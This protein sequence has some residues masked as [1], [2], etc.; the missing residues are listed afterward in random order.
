MLVTASNFGSAISHLH[1]WKGRRLGVDTETTGLEWATKDKMVGVSVWCPEFGYYFPFRH[2]TGNLTFKNMAVLL[3]ELEQQHIVGFNTKFD[4]HI[5]RKD[6]MRYP[7]HIPENAHLLSQLADENEPSLELKALCAR[8]FGPESV[9]ESQKLDALLE[10]KK[11]KKGDI[12]KLDPEEVEPYAVADSKLALDLADFQWKRLSA[13]KL[14][15]IAQEVLDYERITYNM[16][17]R[18]LLLDQGVLQELEDRAG[19]ALEADIKTLSEYFG[20]PVKPRSPKQIKRL[21]K[22]KNTTDETLELCSH[23][24]A[25]V[26]RRAR[27]WATMKSNYCTPY[28]H[29][30]A[31]DGAL[32]PN[33]NLGGTIAGRPSC[34]NP[35]L[36][37]V[38]KSDEIYRIKD[39]FIARPGYTLISADYGQAEMRLGAHYTEDVNLMRI[40]AAGGDT[41]GAV[42]KQNNIDRDSAKRINFGIVYGLGPPGLARQ[43]RITT[44]RAKELLDA[45]HRGFPRFKKTR[46]ATNDA[47]LKNGYIRMWTGRVRRFCQCGY[48]DYCGDSHAPS[49]K[50][51]SNL[52]QGGVGEILRRAIQRMDREFAGMDVHLL[53]Q[54]YDQVLFEVPDALVLQMASEIRRIMED[55]PFRVK[56]KVDISTGRSWGKLTKLP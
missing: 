46:Y 50:A 14:S 6:G 8:H 32:H 29:F 30:L 37:A 20:E 40:L 10:K 49:H 47:A 7:K 19:P 39:V 16:E 11:L 3:H 18:G 43:L 22:T 17:E 15:T 33:Y 21:L 44:K 4:L 9:A 42:A 25:A 5:L 1:G 27:K 2:Q 53:L 24:M 12:A 34:T 36:Q 38:V 55:F 51:F 31:D 13:W 28:R 56:M 48:D 54:V 35:N 26:I 52:I 23:P 41:H 45:W